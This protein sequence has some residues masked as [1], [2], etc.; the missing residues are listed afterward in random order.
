MK[1]P[2]YAAIFLV[3]TKTNSSAGVGIQEYVDAIFIALLYCWR[4]NNVPDSLTWNFEEIVGAILFPSLIL[5]TPCLKF[6][7]LRSFHCCWFFIKYMH[8]WPKITQTENTIERKVCRSLEVTTATKTTNV[9]YS[10]M[11]R[12]PWTKM[13]LLGVKIYISIS[14]F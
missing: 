1:C 8:R 6:M 4:S 2:S 9:V 14:V 12:E 5:G 3:V 7:I 13:Q 11:G 10:R